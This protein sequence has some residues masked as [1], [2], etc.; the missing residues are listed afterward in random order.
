MEQRREDLGAA[1]GGGDHERQGLAGVGPARARQRAE[2]DP[3]DLYGALELRPSKGDFPR[4][5]PFPD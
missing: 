4:I 3:L 5:R 2:D 1:D